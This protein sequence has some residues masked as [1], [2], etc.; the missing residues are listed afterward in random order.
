MAHQEAAVSTEVVSE[1]MDQVTEIEMLSVQFFAAMHTWV[2]YPM[3][4]L[5]AFLLWEGEVHLSSVKEN[6][7]GAI[8]AVSYAKE[9]IKEQARPEGMGLVSMRPLRKEVEMEVA[10]RHQTDEEAALLLVD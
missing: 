10:H 6:V 7:V 8:E 2:E 4:I 9:V 5:V 3:R 1:S